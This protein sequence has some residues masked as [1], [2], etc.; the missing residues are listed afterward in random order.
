MI[1]EDLRG[2]DDPRKFTL[3]VIKFILGVVVGIGLVLGAGFLFIA[4][5]G[6]S[7]STAG[8]PLPMERYL[9][10]TALAASIGDAAE[11]KSPVGVTEADLLEGARLYQQNGCMGCHGALGEG[12]TAKSKAMYPHIPP[13][14]PPSHG[15]TDDPVGETYWVVKNGIRFSGMPSFGAKLSE[16]ELWQITQILHNADKLPQSVQEALR[17][18]R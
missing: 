13:L 12:P 11:Y 10:H 17:A 16:T 5:G 18:K 6:L 2:C 7:L 1:P 8:G 4:R 3:V 14:L 9:A 15:V